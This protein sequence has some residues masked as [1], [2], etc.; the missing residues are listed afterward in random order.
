[1]K[2]IIMLFVLML[3]LFAYG[4]GEA[5]KEQLTAPTDFALADNVISFTEI[6]GA[7]HK[8]V[9][10]NKETNKVYNRVVTNGTS[11]ESLSLA[12]GIYE[13]YIEVSLNNETAVTEVITFVIEDANAVQKVNGEEM[14][15]SEYV[16]LIGRTYVKDETT[17]MISHS[18]SGLTVKFKG[19]NLKVDLTATNSSNAWK[20][21]YVSIIIDGDYDNPIIQ[22]VNSKSIDGFV[23]AE[24]LEYGE[25]EVTFIKRSEALD[26]FIGIK[27]V[28]TDGKL[29]PREDKERFIEILGDSTIAGYGNE[30]KLVGSKYEDKTSGN[31]NVMKTFAYLTAR[32]F[33][34]DYSIVCASGWGL[35]GS[36]WTVPKTVNLLETY[37]R[38]YSTYSE[39]K[40]QHIYSEDY[41]NFS[42]GR[43]ADVM[44]IS[45]GTN[46]LYY[47]EAGYNESKA[48]G[49][50]RKQDFIDK[51]KELLEFITSMYDG[52]QIFMVYG[53]MGEIRMY[54]T[55][56]AA[57]N[58]VKDSMNN[59]HLVKLNGD[60]KAIDYHPSAKGHEEMSEVLIAEVKKVMNW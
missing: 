1:M 30:T 35:T 5:T 59:V 45:V 4:C 52:V 44:I 2:K 8:A 14:M 17:V 10:T 43:K 47:I 33:D 48:I 37:K 21:P 6:E 28:Y 36:E 51:Y 23:L 15:Y 13:I 11:V 49:D 41:Y 22:G 32:E 53:A 27:N 34:A 60:Q 19:T 58:N 40:Q 25:H 56:E 7:K 9:I 54:P 24:N 38:Y 55:V 57:Y 20:R 31:S 29:L 26:S 3:S 39:S 12:A 46:D 42:E 16:K 18:G 50:Q